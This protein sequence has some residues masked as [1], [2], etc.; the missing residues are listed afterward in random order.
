MKYPSAT[1]RNRAPRPGRIVIQKP[2]SLSEKEECPDCMRQGNR[3]QARGDGKLQMQHTISRENKAF[4]AP[5]S[6]SCGEFPNECQHHCR[7]PPGFQ[8][9]ALEVRHHLRFI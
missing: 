4:P 2:V 5:R 8:G 9:V 3:V 1:A 6:R 7:R